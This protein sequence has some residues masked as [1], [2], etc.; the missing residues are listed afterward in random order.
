MN[1]P[2]SLRQIL[3]PTADLDA[4]LAFYE[5]VLGLTLKFRDGDRYAA[6]SAGDATVALLGP[7]D[8]DPAAG[9]APALRAEDVEPL[10]ARLREA[11]LA[12]AGPEDGGHERR[13]ELLD[14]SGNP[15]VVYA[16]L[17]G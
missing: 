10:A 12:F 2:L 8:R 5:G 3:L 16:P 17:P 1:P 6:L 11:G 7:E 15:L 9:V 14:P 4:S 13:I